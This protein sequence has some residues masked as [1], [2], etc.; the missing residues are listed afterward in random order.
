MNLVKDYPR[1]ESYRTLDVSP[2][3]GSGACST[4]DTSNESQF[5]EIEYFCPETMKNAD[6]TKFIIICNVTPVTTNQ[7]MNSTLILPKAYAKLRNEWSYNPP[8][9]RYA[10]LIEIHQSNCSQKVASHYMD[11]YHG[12]GS[13]LSFWS[14]A[15]CNA[16]EQGYRLRMYSPEWVWLDITFCDQDIAKKSPLLCYLPR[17]EFRCGCDEVPPELNITNPRNKKRDGCA[18]LKYKPGGILHEFR[19]ASTEYLFQHVSPLVVHEAE[20]QVGLLFGPGGTPD[21]LITVH[22][23]WGDKYTEMPNR[24]LLTIS[25]YVE[26]ISKLLHDRYGQ[27]RTANIYLAT[28]DPVAFQELQIAVPVG[29][30]IYYDR[31]VEEL[32]RFRPPYGNNAYW[33]SKNSKG[34]AGLASFASMLV[35]MEARLFVLT[36]RSNWSRIINHLRTN[37][38]DPRCNRCTNMVDLVPGIW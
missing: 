12:I 1:D 16:L 5:H 24:A 21:D 3:D 34:R 27:N 37:I 13:H 2:E 17:S 29:W 14:Q 26:A 8:L 31:T 18:L 28:E 15:M 23:R 4:Q 9:S 36:T 7:D 32:S 6:V 38:I 10:K 25:S 11:I 35:A 20:R 22:I 19:A 33:T 30:M